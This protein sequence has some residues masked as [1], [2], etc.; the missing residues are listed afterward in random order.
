MPLVDAYHPLNPWQDRFSM[1]FG[2][3]AS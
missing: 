1:E 2:T 3:N